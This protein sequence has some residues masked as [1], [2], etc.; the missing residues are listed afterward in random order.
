MCIVGTLGDVQQRT[1]VIDGI[2]RFVSFNADVVMVVIFYHY[3]CKVNGRITVHFRADVP[4]I[5]FVYAYLSL[6]I[7]FS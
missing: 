2:L 4:G 5:V 3:I 6:C 1:H 7:V